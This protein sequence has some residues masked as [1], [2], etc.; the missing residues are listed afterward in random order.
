VTAAALDRPLVVT[1][2]AEGTA[3]GAAGL[4]LYSL[5]AVDSPSA[6][7]ELLTASDP[8]DVAEVVARL[9]SFLVLPAGHPL[10]A[11]KVIGGIHWE[12]L[13]L[14]L[15]GAPVYT[16]PARIHDSGK[17]LPKDA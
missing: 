12:A 1:G 17:T 9:W 10:M 14:F 2:A 16:H 13:R 3:L 15:K 5:G 7:V 11:L 4:G 6:G 8:D